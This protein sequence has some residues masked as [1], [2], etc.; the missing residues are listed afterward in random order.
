MYGTTLFTRRGDV[1]L[2]WD[3][4]DDPQILAM[5]E[6]QMRAGVTFFLIEPRLGGMAAPHKVPLADPRDAL[7][8]RTVAMAVAGKDNMLL[9]AL[10]AGAARPVVTPD[11]PVR[12]RKKATAAKEVASGESVGV[13]AGRGG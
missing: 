9:P 5:I 6:A 11:K 12:T 10:E 8:N 2:A 4:P 3:E 7:R 1:T 13:R